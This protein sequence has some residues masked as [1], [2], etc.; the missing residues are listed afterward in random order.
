MIQKVGIGFIAR[1]FTQE[2]KIQ[3]IKSFHFLLL[4]SLLLG[5]AACR[6]P[7]TPFRPE[8][9]REVTPES[10]PAPAV[11]T[12]WPGNITVRLVPE[13]DSAF[14]L[15]LAGFQPGELL[16]FLFIGEIPGA[17]SVSME[18]QPTTRVDADGRF[19]WRDDLRVTP[20]QINLW[21]AKI[22]HARGAACF[23][24]TLPFPNSPLEFPDSRL[25]TPA[26]VSPGA[27][28]VPPNAPQE[29]RVEPSYTLVSRD[30]MIKTA[31]AIFAGQIIDISPTQFNQDSG[32]Y[33]E[34]TTEEGPGLAT[35]HSAWPVYFVEV[36][37]E[38]PFVDEIGLGDTAVLTLLGKSPVDTDEPTNSQDE[39]VRVGG[40]SDYSFRVGDEIIAFVNQT[41]IAW[42]DR[43]PVRTIP[44]ED[45]VT[46]D[47]GRRS[48]LIFANAPHETYLL[49]A[50]DGRY[51]SLP[52]ASEPWPPLTLD[53]FSD[54]IA[55]S[56]PVLVDDNVALPTASPT[57]PPPTATA[58]PLD[59][60]AIQTG[61]PILFVRDDDLWRADVN[62]QNEQR[63]TEGGL[64]ADWFSLNAGGD[65][66]W[67]G[68]FPPQPHI[69]PDG[70]WIAFTQT[71]SNLL[72][73][74]VTGLEETRTH[75]IESNLVFTWSP[76]SRYLAFGRSRI[77]LYDVRADQ[78]T[79]LLDVD[80]RDLLN[81]AWSPDSRFLAFACCFVEPDPYEGVVYGK[82]RQIEWA[83]K[84]V[85]AVGETWARVASG[86][87]SV[88]WSADGAAGIELAEPVSC[89]YERP[90][91]SDSSPDGTQ[92]AYLSLHPS[93]EAE[94]FHWL[95]VEERADDTILWEQEVPLVQRVHWSP[96]GQYL[97]I[98]NDFFAEDPAI[99]RIPAGGGEAEMIL[100][101][102]HLLDVVAAW[103]KVD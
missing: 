14:V 18:S 45:G 29:I 71:G 6:G 51:A 27:T 80:S 26:P 9:P 17:T 75:P 53:E 24:L 20:S 40:D 62:G 59:P 65:F 28:A 4:Y 58:V 70:R 63:L 68:G 47:Y 82:V 54:E 81:L 15:E 103:Q 25:Y 101:G 99:W 60:A 12:S 44:F 36:T 1:T 89:S 42:W 55:S 41:E 73:V 95:V 2:G 66:W 97:I 50:N 48:V 76:D 57:L 74:D 10:S 11:C 21:Q 69:S 35:T 83:T 30:E 31:D 52:G 92:R 72:V 22:I 86:S 85:T 34:L 88:C 98:G 96:N 61:A 102:A 39:T 13:S 23:E 78:I 37:V 77:D 38:R 56:R 84:Q 87:P 43:Q 79:N 19:T 90:Y 8:I 64:L 5:L 16:T 49:R 46:F 33:W 7:S 94:Y 3:M 93:D 67:V 100:P 91:P 32:E